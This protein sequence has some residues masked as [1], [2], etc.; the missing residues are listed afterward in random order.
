MANW[1]S[2][3]FAGIPRIAGRA[4]KSYSSALQKYPVRTNAAT[5]GTLQVVSDAFAQRLQQQDAGQ[6]F[7]LDATRSLTMLGWGGT[8]GGVV[9][10]QWMRYLDKLFPP[11]QNTVLR[12]F[13]KIGVN[14]AAIAP[15]MNGSL[16]TSVGTCS[17]LPPDLLR[18]FKLSACTRSD[19]TRTSTEILCCGPG[20][21]FGVATARNHALTTSQGRT[22]YATS[23]IAHAPMPR[24]HSLPCPIRC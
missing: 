17:Q 12:V 13:A 24:A 11:A 6:G 15:T 18:R 8:I 5:C 23:N 19:K 21:F 14:Q 16:K 1:P 4:W 20:G 22:E 2:G 3:V 10:Y 7:F 9:V